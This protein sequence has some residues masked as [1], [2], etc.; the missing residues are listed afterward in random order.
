MAKPEIEKRVAAGPF[1]PKWLR[2]KNSYKALKTGALFKPDIAPAITKYDN[3]LTEYGALKDELKDMNKI[4]GTM[5]E[6]SQESVT[7]RDGVTKELSDLTAKAKA[8][9]AKDMGEVQKCVAGSETDTD[10][11]VA[12]LNDLADAGKEFVTKRKGLW[13]ELD[14]IAVESNNHHRLTRDK[15]KERADARNA[16]IAALETKAAAAQTEI[17]GILAQYVKIAGDADHDEIAKGLKSLNG[18]FKKK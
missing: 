5:L 17:E 6:K 3:L 18:V 10:P 11:V 13:D 9:F 16:K 12:A 7:A 8:K 15:Y 4:L 2:V 14:G 1:M